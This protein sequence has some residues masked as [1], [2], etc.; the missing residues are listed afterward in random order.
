MPTEKYFD[1]NHVF[2]YIS[3][4]IKRLVTSH[5]I[6]SMIKGKI[7]NVFFQDWTNFGTQNCKIFTTTIFFFLEM[8][9]M[10][11]MYLTEISR[12][13]SKWFLNLFRP[14]ISIPSMHCIAMRLIFASKKVFTPTINYSIICSN[15]GSLL[16]VTGWQKLRKHRSEAEP[17]L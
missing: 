5:N 8:F 17:Q 1:R 11:T 2:K 13:L 3:W 7:M 6:Y 10:K 12:K 4:H 15:F 16:Q 9:N 14:V